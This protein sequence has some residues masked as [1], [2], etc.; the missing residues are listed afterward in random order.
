MMMMMIVM[1]MM[2]SDDD[3]ELILTC[4]LY[5]GSLSLSLSLSHTERALP[6][7]ARLC[8]STGRYLFQPV[9]VA[10]LAVTC[11]STCDKDPSV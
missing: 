6:V 7:S 11:F 8:S 10:Q 5:I 1:I 3:S 4:T 2:M 9:C